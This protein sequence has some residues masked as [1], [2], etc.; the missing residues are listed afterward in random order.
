MTSGTRRAFGK[1]RWTNTSPVVP[2]MTPMVA[3][4]WSSA[5]REPYRLLSSTRTAAIRPPSRYGSVKAIR[6]ARAS[7]T[8]IPDMMMSVRP[9][10]SVSICRSQ[11]TSTKY[12]GRSRRAPRSRARSASTPVIWLP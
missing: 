12:A 8:D 2:S 5:S 11:G 10:I 3:V 9:A 6:T 4:L 1:L 7:V